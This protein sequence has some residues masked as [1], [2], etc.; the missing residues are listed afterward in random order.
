MTAIVGILNKE[1]IAIAADS[2]ATVYGNNN[3]HKIFNKST[4][5]FT[6]SKHHPVGVMIHN[7]GSFLSTPWETI[8]KVYRKNLK[9][10]SFATLK[11][12]MDDFIMFLHAKNFY[13]D[14]ATQKLFLYF[15]FN[16]IV[17]TIIEQALRGQDALMWI[18]RCN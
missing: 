3:S 17:K 4:K 8:I 11:E 10:K 1:A 6:I 13:A 14:E 7:S 15:F 2:A 12:Y 9:E 5:I 18:F 16:S